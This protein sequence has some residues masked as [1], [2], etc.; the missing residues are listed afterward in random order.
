MLAS[1][2]LWV[3]P[4]RRDPAMVTPAIGF[5]LTF[6]AGLVISLAAAGDQQ[7]GLVSHSV[8]ALLA[9][10]LL[11]FRKRLVEQP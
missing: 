1:F 3:W 6:H 7:A 5:L 4:Q 2:S 8:L 11:V 10:V 9:L